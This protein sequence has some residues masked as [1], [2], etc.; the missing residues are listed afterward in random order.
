MLNQFNGFESKIAKNDILRNVPTVLGFPRTGFT[1]LISII[2]ELNLI[3]HH[4]DKPN[5]NDEISD[6]FKY[7]SNSV[8]D[9]IE[10]TLRNYGI[11]NEIIFNKNFHHPL[12]GPNWIDEEKNTLCI[13]K[14]IG[15]K[16][17]GDLTVIISLPLDYIYYHSIPHS[18]GPISPWINDNNQIFHSIRSPAGTINSA[19]HSI[20]ALTSEYIQ[21]WRPN[22]SLIEEESIRSNLALTKLSDL[23]FFEAMVKPM[24]SSFRELANLSSQVQLYK[25]EDIIANPV[26]T[27][28]RISDE[29]GF[30]TT[31]NQAAQIWSKIG[32]RNLTQNHQHNHRNFGSKLTGHYSS[33]INEHIE[34]LRSY[35]FTQLARELGVEPPSYIDP[36][37]YNDF[38]KS[39]S[40]SI[41]SDEKLKY[42]EDEELYWLSFQKSNIDFTK[43]DFKVFDWKVHSKLER[44]NIQDDMLTHQIWD[45]FERNVQLLTAE[46]T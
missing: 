31:V 18:H 11:D 37:C 19:V 16:G 3:A 29:L 25:W 39:L 36:K 2:T 43:F 30:K 24:Q 7:F 4:F 41:A 14:Y 23:N 12:G 15:I 13:R 1:L 22:L 34:M 33:L 8:P 21:R 20:N 32:H 10:S 44:T 40:L 38:Q 46:Y 27:I 9:E 5:K 35:D 17:L 42:T 26:Q 6:R 28:L 45:V